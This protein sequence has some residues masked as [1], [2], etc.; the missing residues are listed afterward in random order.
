M[1]WNATGADYPHQLCV[2]QW[3]EREAARRPEALAVACGAE[4]L[5]YGQLNARAN[6]LAHRLRALG[7]RPEVLVAVC[8]ERCVGLAAAVLAV[9]KAGGAYVPLDPLW[10]PERL[11][12]LLRELRPAAVPS[13][14]AGVSRLPASLEAPVVQVDPPEAEEGTATDEDPKGATN[15]C[16]EVTP[17]NLAYVIYT[18]GSTGAPKGVMIEHRRVGEPQLGDCAAIRSPSYR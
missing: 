6:R 7:V 17:A 18:S 9:W 13:T 3:F 11:G 4:A 16:S 12:R 15:P 5:S 10:P 1:S 2:H 14:A 8:L